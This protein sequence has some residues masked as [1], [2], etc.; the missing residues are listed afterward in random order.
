M[1]GLP[2]QTGE[3]DA[4][5]LVTAALHEASSSTPP[6][7]EG[8]RELCDWLTKNVEEVSSHAPRYARLL[9]QEGYTPDL[10]ERTRPDVEA[11]R[12]MGISMHAHRALIAAFIRERR[13]ELDTDTIYEGFRCRLDAE[14]SI[15]VVS[16]LFASSAL[17]M[18]DNMENHRYVNMRAVGVIIVGAVNLFCVLVSSMVYFAGQRILSRS[19]HP[20]SRNIAKFKLFWDSRQVELI[21][22]VSREMFVLCIPLFMLI[23]TVHVLHVLEHWLAAICTVFLLVMGIGSVLCSNHILTFTGAQVG[24]TL[25]EVLF[26]SRVKAVAKGKDKKD[27]Q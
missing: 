21:R 22:R 17:G 9:A 23:S 26:G 7:S 2:S 10:L 5:A 13:P 16:A 8:E 19:R 11:L 1:Q 24:R 14:A 3:R 20:R 15:A 12:E 4:V 18:V 25:R 27:T 6:L